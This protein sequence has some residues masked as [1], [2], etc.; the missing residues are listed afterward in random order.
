MA[1]A[2]DSLTPH[3]VLPGKVY[4]ADE[5]NHRVQVFTSEGKFLKMFGRPG[6]G[7]DEL[8]RP[9]GVV[10]DSNDMVQCHRLKEYIFHFFLHFG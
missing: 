4:V 2:R 1:V 3:M 8:R 9:D 7:R 6:A 5:D 10:I